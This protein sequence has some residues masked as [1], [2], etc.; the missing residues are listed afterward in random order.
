VAYPHVWNEKNA[1]FR[2]IP[3]YGFADYPGGGLKVS[4]AD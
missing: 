3:L 2:T 1:V 4:V